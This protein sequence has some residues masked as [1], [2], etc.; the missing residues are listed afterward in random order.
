MARRAL[1]DGMAI[2]RPLMG[3]TIWWGEAE[4]REAAREMVELADRD[5]RLRGILDAVRSNRIE[6]DFSP[7]WSH[8]RE[9]LE[10]KL[11][12][13]RMKVKVSFVELTNTVPV[14]G[15]ESEVHEQLLWEDFLPLLDPKERRIVI[16][17]RSGHT[18]L[19]DV[20]RQLGYANHS[21]I[22]KALARIRGKVRRL[23]EN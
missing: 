12:H 3:G 15:P 19:G 21:P 10:R 2:D 1:P 17:L 11:Y 23:L 18:N 20:G 5:G 13:T 8:A 4:A 14:H 16:L 9:D 7:R 22:S 6:E